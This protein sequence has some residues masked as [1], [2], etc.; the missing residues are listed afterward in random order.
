MPTHLIALTRLGLRAQRGRN[1]L[2]E[3]QSKQNVSA[4]VGVRQGRS[5]EIMV[6][7]DQR[8]QISIFIA[9]QIA[10]QVDAE[11]ADINKLVN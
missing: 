8:I 5:L 11:N 7:C 6:T 10:K 4:K 3:P 9:K 1:L 2:K